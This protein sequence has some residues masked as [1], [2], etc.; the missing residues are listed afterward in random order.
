[1]RAGDVTGRRAGGATGPGDGPSVGR[2][3]G[4][5][6]ALLVVDLLVIAYLVLI[7]YG[8]TGWA[9]AYD[10][11]N[12]PDAPREALRGMWF[13]VGGA[14]V[15]GAGLLVLGWRV[16]GVVQLVVLGTGAGL[17]ACLAARG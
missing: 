11:A 7:R 9:D 13:L 5:A 14:G 16:P 2:Q 6:L 10:S 17:L 15:T 8:M 12:P 3:V 4:V 1:M